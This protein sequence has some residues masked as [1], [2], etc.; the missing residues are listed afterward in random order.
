VKTLYGCAMVLWMVS[1]VGLHAYF[2]RAA[3]EP[4]AVEAQRGGSPRPFEDDNRVAQR[5]REARWRSDATMAGT[6]LAWAVVGVVLAMPGVRALFRMADRVRETETFLAGSVLLLLVL[7][8]GLRQPVEPVEREPIGRNEGGVVVP[9]T[10]DT[11]RE[12]AFHGRIAVAPC[13][14]HGADQ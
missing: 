4:A 10:G 7:S 14:R 2:S 5:I 1:G 8:G 3:Q 9:Y 11:P 13:D 12:T 6:Y